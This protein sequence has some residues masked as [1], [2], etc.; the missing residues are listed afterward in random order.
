V[1]AACTRPLASCGGWLE[2]RWQARDLA[3]Q[4]PPSAQLAVR[5]PTLAAQISRI[6]K[7]AGLPDLN[8]TA[9]QNGGSARGYSPSIAVLGH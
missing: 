5:G 6:C 1:N 3:P 4:A 2:G 9:D 8:C 7:A